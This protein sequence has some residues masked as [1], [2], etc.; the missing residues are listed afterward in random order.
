MRP[1]CHQ[2]TPL[3][4]ESNEYGASIMVVVSSSQTTFRKIFCRLPGCHNL[5]IICSPCYRNHKYCSKTCSKIA[6]IENRR[7]ARRR[8]RESPEGKANGRDLQR[9]YRLRKAAL[10]RAEAE[11]KKTVMDNTTNIQTASGII[12]SP[13]STAPI[14]AQRRPFLSKEGEIICLFCGR[15]GHFIDQSIESG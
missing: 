4:N 13:S 11:A 5:F 15:T 14:E 1:W 2:H 10:A 12:A 8:Y 9:K 3:S 7:A 6:D